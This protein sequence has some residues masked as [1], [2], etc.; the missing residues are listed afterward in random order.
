MAKKTIKLKK[1]VD[2]INE[3]VAAGTITPGMLIE[4]DSN[5]EMQAH[6]TAGGPAAK[7][8]ALEDEL[9]GKTIEDN[10]VADDQVQCWM[11]V[12]GEEVLGILKDDT[13]AVVK[14]DFLE[15]AGGGMLQKHDPVE[16]ANSE[17][18]MIYTGQIVG[19]ALEDV[20]LSDSSS[21]EESSGVLGYHKRIKIRIV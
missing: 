11:C 7:V 5:G 15:S 20:D 10:Y 12:P 6:D 16:W 9:Q 1:Y 21:A 8:F 4:M 3:Y 2:I 17:S 19:I 13:D 14:G 18:G